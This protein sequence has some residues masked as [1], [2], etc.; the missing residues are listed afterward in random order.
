MAGRTGRADGGPKCVDTVCS[1]STV[2]RVSDI[3]TGSHAGWVHD[4]GVMGAGGRGAFFEFDA[5]EFYI[6]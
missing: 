2:S 6:R 1:S 3:P 5:D 4:P